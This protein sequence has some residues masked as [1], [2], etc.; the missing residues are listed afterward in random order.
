MFTVTWVQARALEAVFITEASVVPEE[1]RIW[2]SCQSYLTVSVVPPKYQK[3]S[4]AVVA[5]AGMV[6][7]WTRL[8]SPVG[9]APVVPEVPRSADEAPECLWAPVTTG[10]GAPPP[11]V[12]DANEP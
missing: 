5:D 10:V 8:L 1:L 2:A 7:V 9:S 4:V 12:Q 3:L 11:V 6:T